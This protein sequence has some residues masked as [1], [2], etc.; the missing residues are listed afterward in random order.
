MKSKG[1]NALLRRGL[2]AQAFAEMNWDHSEACGRESLSAAQ[3]LAL[4]PS[5]TPDFER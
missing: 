1:R 2:R 4:N 3:L 5:W